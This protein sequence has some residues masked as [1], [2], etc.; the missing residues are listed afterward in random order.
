MRLLRDIPIEQWIVPASTKSETWQDIERVIEHP[1][2]NQKLY[3][4]SDQL[5]SHIWQHRHPT[6]SKSREAKVAKTDDDGKPTPFVYLRDDGEKSIPVWKQYEF[7]LWDKLEE[8]RWD[9][10][11]NPIVIIGLPPKEMVQRVFLNQTWKKGNTKTAK[12][13]EQIDKFDDDLD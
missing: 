5:K 8:P 13:I 9:L 6:R 2:D 4:H 1:E 7:I 3:F 12:I 10:E 11:E